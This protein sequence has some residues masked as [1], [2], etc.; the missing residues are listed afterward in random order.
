M[1]VHQQ[2]L[3]RLRSPNRQPITSAHDLACLVTD[4]CTGFLDRDEVQGGFHFLDFFEREI[5]RVV[6]GCRSFSF[7]HPS[8]YVGKRQRLNTN[9]FTPE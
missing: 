7:T 6:R 5:A 2:V 4:T 8:S 9:T 3:R 1:N